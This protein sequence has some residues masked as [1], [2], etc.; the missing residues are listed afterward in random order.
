[1][2]KLKYVMLFEKFMQQLYEQTPIDEAAGDTYDYHIARMIKSKITPNMTEKDKISLINHA[3]KDDGNNIVRVR[4][5]MNDE[6]FIPDV[7]S[8]LDEI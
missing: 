4:N 1:M 8:V 2:T 6:D 3:L 5:Y 7:L